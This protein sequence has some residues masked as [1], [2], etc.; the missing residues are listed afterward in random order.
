MPDETAYTAVATTATGKLNGLALAAASAI[1]TPP[2]RIIG[3]VMTLPPTPRKLA[4]APMPIP[5]A[6]TP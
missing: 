1:G 6:R 2:R 5:T 3:T 4:T